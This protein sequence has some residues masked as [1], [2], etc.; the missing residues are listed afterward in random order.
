MKKILIVDDDTWLLDILNMFLS[1]EGYDVKICSD[2]MECISLA[3]SYQPKLIFLDVFMRGQDGISISKE[4]KLQEVTKNIPV[5]I[6]SASNMD[7]EVL[8]DSHAEEFLQKP[9][10]IN[11]LLDKI[12][13]YT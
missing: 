12:K 5:I 8:K 4:L 2:P 9:F 7:L 11:D 3:T 10:E 1:E 6:Y 13:K